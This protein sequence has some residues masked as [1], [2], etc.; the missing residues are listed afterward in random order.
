MFI[1]QIQLKNF[2]K[3]SDLTVN[4]T[5]GVNTI[6][7]KTG[8]GKSCIIRAL[9]W[10]LNDITGDF[11]RKE[12]TKKTE[13]T[14]KLDNGIKITRVRSDTVNRYILENNGE[15][16]EF[17]SIGKT[18]PEKIKS[19]LNVPILKVDKEELLLNVHTQLASPFL[20]GDT[21]TYRSKVLNALTGNDIL[22]A[23]LRSYNRDLLELSKNT[24]NYQEEI[25]EKQEL[26]TKFKQ[27]HDNIKVI[28]DNVSVIVTSVKTVQERVQ[29]VAL[30]SEQII[31]NNQQIKN[32][33]ETLD[34]TVV[35]SNQTTE[36]LTISIEDYLTIYDIKQDFDRIVVEINNCLIEMDDCFVYEDTAQLCGRVEQYQ[37]VYDLLLK[38]IEN[39]RV[40]SEI[41][42]IK[43]IDVEKIDINSIRKRLEQL[44]I[45]A[46]LSQELTLKVSAI[47]NLVLQEKSLTG[48][49][50]A[51][52]TKYNQLVEKIPV[53]KCQKCGA[54]VKE[55]ERKQL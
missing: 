39:N 30:L 52:I 29:K 45:V 2:Q 19:I 18:L 54:D 40:K 6:V 12:G 14:I 28:Y 53:I 34:N 41:D 9:R 33:Q 47:Q 38:L 42:K 21:G 13:V 35:L 26:I 23:V 31:K 55:Y 7:G 49:I 5:N 46:R 1:K 27:E 25:K 36:N 3:H 8:A 43:L 37:I 16:E 24:R 50:N 4:L 44:E 11:L 48:Q 10:I 20:L 15:T 22:E 32:N 17:N 51:E